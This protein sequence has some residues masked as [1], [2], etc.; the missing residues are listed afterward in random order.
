MVR[1]VLTLE[2][3]HGTGEPPL[4][5]L[6]YSVMALE[7]FLDEQL[8]ARL[9][10]AGRKAF[11]VEHHKS[12]LTVRWSSAVKQ[13]A[14]F[15]PLAQEALQDMVTACKDDSSF[16]LLV[17]ARNKLVHPGR[18]TEKSDAVRD[19]IEDDSIDRLIQEVHKPPV[20]LPHIS[21]QFPAML[22]C[23][24]SARWSWIPYRCW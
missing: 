19:K 13:L 21:A 4:L 3:E 15:D 2:N 24:A 5:V 20:S 11:L 8:D 17:R 10:T 12:K 6:L 7:A 1:T 16:D 23:R 18:F 14:K 9:G 22:T